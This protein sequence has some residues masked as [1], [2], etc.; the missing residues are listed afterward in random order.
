LVTFAFIVYVAFFSLTHKNLRFSHS[1]RFD[2]R[3]TCLAFTSFVFLFSRGLGHRICYKRRQ[4]RKP[5]QIFYNFSLDILWHFL[6]QSR[7]KRNET[8]KYIF[9]IIDRIVFSKLL[10]IIFVYDFN[11]F[12]ELLQYDWLR[13]PNRTIV[14]TDLS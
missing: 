13:E 6:Y 7:V 9:R 1:F 10:K 5:K 8:V 3:V 2:S 11:Y 4:C 12:C 14:K